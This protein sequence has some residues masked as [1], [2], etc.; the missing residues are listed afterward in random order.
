MEYIQHVATVLTVYG[1]ETLYWT[2]IT[3][4]FIIVAT[5]LTVYGIET[6]ADIT[7][8]EFIAFRLQQYLPFT[9]L[10]RSYNLYSFVFL[11]TLQQYLPFTVLK[12]A[13]I[14]HCILVHDDPFVATVLTVYGI[15]TSHKCKI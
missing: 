1:I 7:D 13:W 9:V 11:S 4:L 3:P 12:L 15:E 5:V 6:N 14:I 10:K 8:V 2:T